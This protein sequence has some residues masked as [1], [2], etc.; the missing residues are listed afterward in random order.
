MNKYLLAFLIPLFAGLLLGFGGCEDMKLQLP[1]TIDLNSSKV[2]TTKTPASQ[3][4]PKPKPDTKAAPRP[5]SDGTSTLGST[6]TGEHVG[7]TIDPDRPP[8]LVV[9]ELTVRELNLELDLKETT[10]PARRAELEHEIGLLRAQ[11]RTLYQ[12]EAKGT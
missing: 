10:D 9:L 2:P 7:Q 6:K 1:A 3:A 5:A 4:Q 11:R 8:Q 12:A